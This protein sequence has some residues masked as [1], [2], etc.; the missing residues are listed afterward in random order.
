MILVMPLAVNAH[1]ANENLRLADL[2]AATKIVALTVADL[3][4]GG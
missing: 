2:R 4:R 3:L 1:N